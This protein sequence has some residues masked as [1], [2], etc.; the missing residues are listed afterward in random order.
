MNKLLA[1][2]FA[3]TFALGAAAP[4]MAQSYSQDQYRY[5]QAQRDYERALRQYEAARAQYERERQ[6]WERRYGPGSYGYG[7]P[8]P[9]YYGDPYGP[10]P[11]PPPPPPV[12]DPYDRGYPYD[13]RYDPGYFDPYAPYRNSACER[14]GG[15]R[16]AGT[17]IGALIGGALGAAVAGDS[18]QAEGAVL[19]A[20]VGGTIGNNIAANSSTASRYAAQCDSYGYYFTYDQTF[21]YREGAIDRRGRSG[22]Y[23]YDYYTRQ[24]CRLAVAPYGSPYGRAD[25]RYVRVCPDRQGRYRITG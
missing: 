8:A 3:G 2:L 19:G 7:Y 1:S 25:Y 12:Y 23:D 6:E 4:A 18:S 10:P 17:V 9:P 14:Q 21:P 22:R 5:E 16:A 15:D 13:N 11:P 24:G 20:I